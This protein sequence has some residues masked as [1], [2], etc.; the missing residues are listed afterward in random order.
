MNLRMLL[1][2]AGALSTS[3]TAQTGPSIQR[4]VASSQQVGGE[5][6]VAVSPQMPD[7]LTGVDPNKILRWTL[8]DAILAALEKNPDLEIE[9]ENVRLAQFNLLAAQGVYDPLAT[10]TIS[11]NRDRTPNLSRF[12][13]SSQNFLQID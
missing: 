2:L 5:A 8:K 4:A 13:G 6:P 9:R 11:Y 10:S 12:S 3:A 1:L 7:R